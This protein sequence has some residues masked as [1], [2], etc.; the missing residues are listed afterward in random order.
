MTSRNL[1]KLEPPLKLCCLIKVRRI[2]FTPSV[3]L[4]NELK[5]TAIV[6][7][8]Y[9]RTGKEVKRVTSADPGTVKAIAIKNGTSSEVATKEF[10]KESGG[11]ETIP[12]SGGN[13]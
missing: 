7:T 8:C 12:S 13:G 6:I 1:F 4:K 5:S 11:N 3:E 10:T 2:V 9:D